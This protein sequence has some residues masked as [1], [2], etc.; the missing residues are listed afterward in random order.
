VL[1]SFILFYFN[2]LLRRI[3]VLIKLLD[4]GIP[5][6][7]VTLL[8]YWYAHQDVNVR[9]HNTQSDSFSIENG[10]LQGGILSSYLFTIFGSC[11][12][13]LSTLISAV[14]LAAL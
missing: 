5:V 1:Y 13:Q 2:S 9:W 12:A 3:N 4:E 8:S 7:I 6:D 10:T 14:M 11:C